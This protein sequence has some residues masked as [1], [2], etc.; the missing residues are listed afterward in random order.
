M[1]TVAFSTRNSN[2]SS[3]SNSTDNVNSTSSAVL[4]QDTSSNPLTTTFDLKPHSSI[5]ASL[6]SSI[7]SGTTITSSSTDNNNLVPHNFHHN[8]SHISTSILLN[9]NNNNSSDNSV[10]TDP[11]YLFPSTPTTPR[12]LVPLT[13][14]ASSSSH[15]VTPLHLIPSIAPLISTTNQT[16]IA[17]PIIPPNDLLIHSSSTYVNSSTSNSNNSTSNIKHSLSTSHNKMPKL[18]E[19]SNEALSN[20]NNDNINNINSS[21]LSVGTT[22]ATI[23]KSPSVASDISSTSST[24]TGSSSSTGTFI[25]PTLKSSKRS[26]S[27][28]NDLLYERDRFRARLQSFNNNALDISEDY[29]EP[30]AT[31]IINTHPTL[32]ENG[33]GDID[34]TSINADKECD[35]CDSIG[36]KT[37]K[38]NIHGSSFTHQTKKLIPIDSYA[39]TNNSISPLDHNSQFYKT[40]LL[41][42]PI[43]ISS[44]FTIKSITLSQLKSVFSWYFNSQLPKTNEMFPWLHGLNKDNFAQKQFFLHQQQ[45]LQRKLL[46]MTP[47]STSNSENESNDII[48]YFNE[49]KLNKPK[50]I[51]FLMCVDSST[52]DPN[53]MLSM[54][55]V[56]ENSNSRSENSDRDMVVF[57]NTIKLNE[58]LSKIEVSKLEVKNI[59]VEILTSIGLIN[60]ID[61]SELLQDCITLNSLPIFLNLDPDRGIS[62]RNFHIQVSKLSTCSDFI[63]YNS[64]LIGSPNLKFQYSIARLLWIAQQYESHLND[65]EANT[66]SPYNV[67]IF[68]DSQDSLK[69]LRDSSGNSGNDKPSISNFSKIESKFLWEKYK[70]YKESQSGIV[71]N[72]NNQDKESVAQSSPLLWENDYQ[73]KEKIETTRMSSATKLD[74]NIWCGNYWDYQISLTFILENDKLTNFEEPSQFIDFY[75]QPKNS[76][77]SQT[78]N[79]N[80]NLLDYLPLPR[81]NWRLFIYCHNDATF[82]DLSTLSNLLFKSTI[83]SHNPKDLDDEQYFEYHLL[84]FPPSGS[85]GIGDCKPENLMSIINTCKLIYLYSSSTQVDAFGSLIYCSDGYT[86]SSLL[87]LCYLMYA[88]N[89]S[90]D[91]AMLELHVTFGRPF[92]IFNSDVI[93]LRKLETL[94]NKLSPENPEYKDMINWN[95][96]EKLTSVEVNE[97]L[98]GPLPSKINKSLRLGYIENDDDSDDSDDNEYNEEIENDEEDDEVVNLSSESGSSSTD[99]FHDISEYLLHNPVIDWVKDVEGSIPSKILPYLYLGSLKHANCLPLLNKLGIKKV[100][101]V[102][103]VLDWLNG[104]EFKKFNDIQIEDVDDGNIEMY[105]ISS[106]SRSK[107]HISA[108]KHRKNQK[109][110]HKFQHHLD[111]SVDSVM[112][113]NNLEDDGIDELTRSL[114]AILQFI[115]NEYEKSNGNTKIFIHCRVGVSRSATVVIAE[116]MRRLKINLPTAY[117]YVRVR[118]LNIIIQPNL[119]FMYELFKWEEF[120]KLKARQEETNA[121]NDHTNDHDNDHDP[122]LREIDW[123][124]MCR[125]IMKLNI[126]YLTT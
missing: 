80:A 24:T 4:T 81:A 68:T 75:C 110:H 118:R 54:D 11:S 113:V 31:A 6:D 99:S 50:G 76:I 114:P 23:I 18:M 124:M 27:T 94:L 12:S 16:D 21:N 83:Q 1:S 59:L 9:S 2:S 90:L 36:S 60:N 61:L 57:K 106:S 65:P 30:F 39:D 72:D 84:E 77:V 100:I 91:D 93:I 7:S 45:Q 44:V 67:F 87:V 51:R 19:N 101:S 85:I 48:Q 108:Q 26:S 78:D 49:Y 79:V 98:L 58:I 62:L 125:E 46:S 63:V 25:A 17:P 86:E 15:P 104:S 3:S 5:S 28:S 69:S 38:L 14:L 123:F 115:N 42:H 122:Y 20:T 13:E 119:R 111:C 117:L 107:A 73:I 112:K 120:Q 64:S 82:P 33:N 40:K 32:H 34:S 66:E 35:V 96:L 47:S 97:I 43:S 102:G 92:Y 70:R 95:Q 8:H 22:T 105:K 103:E 52:L 126:P 53:D 88:H 74:R 56:M 41:I 109:K 121:D 71:D 29:T 55:G 89:I 10:T 37:T 116:V